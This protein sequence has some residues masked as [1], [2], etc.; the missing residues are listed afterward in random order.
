MMFD[1]GGVMYN[2]S[3]IMLLWRGA[4]MKEE[5][6]TPYEDV[7]FDKKAFSQGSLKGCPMTVRM[8]SYTS[9][10]QNLSV[11]L[12]FALKK[13]K[14]GSQPVLY[15]ISCQNYQPIMGVRMNH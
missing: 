15:A 4:S 11:G 10:S 1:L 2:L 6:I 5:W 7:L 8:E 13:P 9:C 3:G 14:E 12:K